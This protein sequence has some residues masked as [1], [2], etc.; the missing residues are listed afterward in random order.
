MFKIFVIRL[1][2][3][4]LQHYLLCEIAWTY[5]SNV[6]FYDGQATQ[7]YPLWKKYQPFDCALLGSTLE[8]S[9]SEDC[10]L[11]APKTK[12]YAY[13]A[14]WKTFLFSTKTQHLCYQ[15]ISALTFLVPYLGTPPVQRHRRVVPFL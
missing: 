8:R 9:C 1:N 7:E 15:N 6:A 10:I 13:L 2:P 14:S 11:R 3:K 12:A 5:R 4:T